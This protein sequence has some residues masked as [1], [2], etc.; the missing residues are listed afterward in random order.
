[1]ALKTRHPKT[2]FTVIITFLFLIIT[3]FISP[4]IN[5]GPSLPEVVATNESIWLD[6]NWTEDEKR[7][8]WHES[9]GANTFIIPYEW[10]RALEQ[11]VLAPSIFD[12]P[13]LFVDPDYL[14]R[15]G[16]I[17]S[18]KSK[19]N[20][21]GLPIGFALTENMTDPN[22]KKK[23]NALGFTCAACHTGKL[24]YNGTTI[25]VDGAPANIDIRSLD[26]AMAKAL[27]LTRYIPGRFDRMAKRILGTRHTAETQAALKVE[28]GQT[29]DK[30]QSVIWW[31]HE[32]SDRHV[33]EGSG[34][35]DAIN[36]IGNQLFAINTGLSE[37][38]VPLT[39]PISIPQIWGTPWMQGVQYDSAVISP[40]LRNVGEALGVVG[41]VDLKKDSPTQFSSTIPFEKINALEQL[42]A[43]PHPPTENNE[44]TGLQSPKWPRNILGEIDQTKAAAGQKLYTTMCT[45]CHLPP[46]N[47]DQFWNPDH[48]TPPK[49]GFSYLKTPTY[50]IGTDPAR[51]DVLKRTVNTVGLGLKT[52]VCGETV[53]SEFETDYTLAVL[54]V[55]Q[56]VID[57]GFKENS[58][59]LADQNQMNGYRPE[60]VP[61]IPGYKARPL[62][63]IWATAP[64]LHNG[65]IPNLYDLLSPVTERPTTFYTGSTKFDPIKVG[66][67][68][69]HQDGLFEFNTL[70]P[71]NLNTGHE[72]NKGQPDDP[73]IIGRLLT[74]PERLALIE[75]LKTL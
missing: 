70:L 37:N 23:F 27:L 24:D 21:T 22:T 46:T 1:M 65:S 62:D 38:F 4:Q 72:F 44:F 29:M 50:K 11:P 41:L 18:P 10:F 47:T 20:P 58:I 31:D 71:G 61:T 16:F 53:Y 13:S 67:R 69:E 5:I 45:E 30:I 51:Y 6:Q 40:I 56:S 7:W 28:F 26:M 2:F 66:Y 52:K 73:G 63:G 57:K 35:I 33:A 14:L 75:Y 68:S 48:W 74:P 12:T 9:Q 34:R 59:P 36:R 55:V 3:L 64:F 49:K 15:F 8:Y 32:A 54:A 19:Y 25:L 60:C 17:P 43:G 42:L 39:A